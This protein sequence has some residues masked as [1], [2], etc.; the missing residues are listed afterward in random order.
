MPGD[1]SG[2]GPAL[3]KI[4]ERGD[5]NLAGFKPCNALAVGRDGNLCNGVGAI[6]AGKDFVE[7]DA[8]RG[9]IGWHR[10]CGLSMRGL[11][12]NEGDGCGAENQ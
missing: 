9:D 11:R 2:D 10:G 4:V 7:L 8:R 12:V 1:G 5:A 6:P 3:D